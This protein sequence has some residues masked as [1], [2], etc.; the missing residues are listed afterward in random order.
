MKLIG[1]CGKARS[2]KDTIAKYLWNQHAFTRIAFADPVKLAAQKIFG[3]TDAQTWN[4]DLKEVEIPYWGMSPRR[5][6][7][8]VGTE[9]GRDIF[10]YDLWIKRFILSY[11]MFKHTDDV[12][13]PDVRFD[14]EAET[15]R[16][17]GGIIIEVRRG[18]GLAGEAAQHKSEAGLSLPPD[19]VIT[20][21]GTLAELY[22]KVNYVVG[23]C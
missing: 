18:Q 3:L 2:G 6:F 13:V 22:A 8:L 9:G 23:S 21:E 10:G 5:M 1:I 4:D 7:Q 15:I 12:V 19:N 17:L 14:N 11:S 16:E 20:N